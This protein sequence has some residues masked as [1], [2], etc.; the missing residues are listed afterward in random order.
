MALKVIKIAELAEVNA[1]LRAGIIGGID[2]RRGGIYGLGAKTM[3]FTT[4]AVTVTFS[5]PNDHPQEKLTLK[6]IVDQIN[7][8]ALPAG[9][10]RAL[11]GQLHLELPTPGPLVT[12][13]GTALALLGL[14]SG[15]FTTELINPAGGATPTLESIFTTPL[16]G[17][18]YVLVIDE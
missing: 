6:E 14:P 16:S 12:S 17:A 5:T 10:A 8:T 2:L 18:T 9:T 1:F 15:G 3:V 4:P 13:G 11:N 7:A